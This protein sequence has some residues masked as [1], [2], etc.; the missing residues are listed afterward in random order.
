MGGHCP[1]R[2]G[3]AEDPPLVKVFS[4]VPPLR[5]PLGE[6]ERDTRSSEGYVERLALRHLGA[7]DWARFYN[8]AR[9]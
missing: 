3:P 5:P 6:Y 7:P 9:F 1:S 2:L 8:P 4:E